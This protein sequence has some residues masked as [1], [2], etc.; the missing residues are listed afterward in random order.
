LG[1]LGLGLLWVHIC[2]L[3][4]FYS[5]LPSF[6]QGVFTSSVSLLMNKLGV[7]VCLLSWSTKQLL[8]WKSGEIVAAAAVVC[9]V[10]TCCREETLEFCATVEHKVCMQRAAASELMYRHKEFPNKLVP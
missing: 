4:A 8:V 1:S 10:V 7:K 5:L 6:F 2:F 3:A 9:W